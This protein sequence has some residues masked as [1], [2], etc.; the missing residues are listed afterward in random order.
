MNDHSHRGIIINPV[1][2]YRHSEGKTYPIELEVDIWGKDLAAAL[3]LRKLMGYDG[4]DYTVITEREV[5]I[6]P[7]KWSPTYN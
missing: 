1:L 2:G 5:W 3:W 4:D 7:F 6:N